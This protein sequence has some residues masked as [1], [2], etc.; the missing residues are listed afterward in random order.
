MSKAKAVVAKLKTSYPLNPKAII[1]AQV[2]YQ[3]LVDGLT[4][5]EALEKELGLEGEIL[6]LN[7]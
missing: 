3:S 4:A 2:E 1:E 6:D 7:D 5:L